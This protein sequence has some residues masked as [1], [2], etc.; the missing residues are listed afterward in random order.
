[1]LNEAEQRAAHGASIDKE[2]A[3]VKETESA[4]T[5]AFEVRAQTAEGRLASTEEALESLEREAAAIRG[6]RD[7]LLS[8]V[9]RSEA[10]LKKS[11]DDL[12]LVKKKQAEEL[13]EVKK[14]L[15]DEAA[16]STSELIHRHSEEM[17]QAKN[18]L[19]THV[20]NSKESIESL[21]KELFLEK[22]LRNEDLSGLRSNLGHELTQAKSEL[23]SMRALHA[24]EVAAMRKEASQSLDD[25]RSQL[26]NSAT[27]HRAH[28]DEELNDLR[29]K[30]D[31]ARA[32]LLHS[33]NDLR[34]LEDKLSE[35][36]S[37]IAALNS[38]SAAAISRAEAAER[39]RDRTSENLT[40]A[41]A[42]RDN[43]V[44]RSQAL[45]DQVDKLTSESNIIYKKLEGMEASIKETSSEAFVTAQESA[46]EKKLLKEAL[47]RSERKLLEAKESMSMS[48]NVTA[49][50]RVEL[51]NQMRELGQ[52]RDELIALQSRLVAVMDEGAAFKADA[53]LTQV[54]IERCRSRIVQLQRENNDIRSEVARLRDESAAARADA[55]RASRLIGGNIQSS[56]ASVQAGVA[57]IRNE[58]NRTAASSSSSSSSETPPSISIVNTAPLSSPSGPSSRGSLYSPILGRRLP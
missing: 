22:E 44:L 2:L 42:E 43:L 18:D 50:L 20:S 36:L 34:S 47:S 51:K 38:S 32:H 8:R 13:N 53:E 25:L 37:R 52:A 1:M 58:L 16:R 24:N 30:L 21:R 48:E 54:E 28:A 15:H 4:R 14:R 6:E 5:R 46:E 23:L 26:V 29:R 9:D 35:A 49:A 10:A 27:R 56:L 39:S 11:N 12:S 40:L 7:A 33:R 3:T 17:L 55:S 45:S 31:D 41:L 19:A 57:E